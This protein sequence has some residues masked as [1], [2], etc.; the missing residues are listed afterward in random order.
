MKSFSLLLVALLFCSVLFAQD[1]LPVTAKPDKTKRLQMADAACGQCKFGL[2]GGDC[3][4]AVRIKDSAYF[5][6]GTNIDDHGNAHAKNGFC[7]A[8]RKAEVQGEVIN[9]RFKASYFK[10][11]KEAAKKD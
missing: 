5:V 7:N 1:S 8:I 11:V 2:T 6:D 4:L 9:G 10:L 3:D